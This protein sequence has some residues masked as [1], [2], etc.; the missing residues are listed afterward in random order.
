[1]ELGVEI[2]QSD[3]AAIADIPAVGA[4]E[5]LLQEHGCGNEVEVGCINVVIDPFHG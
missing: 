3:D 1:L 5:L 4:G 2:E